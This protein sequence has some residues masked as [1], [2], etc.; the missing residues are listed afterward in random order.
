MAPVLAPRSEHGLE[1]DA[2]WHTE[3]EI[4]QQLRTS[5][6]KRM[7]DLSIMT[8]IYKEARSERLWCSL[9][10]LQG[11]EHDLTFHGGVDK[12][13]HQYCPQHYSL[14]VAEYPDEADAFVPGAFGENVVSE[15]MYEGNVC[16]GDVVRIGGVLL[17]VSLP[18]Q[19]CFKLNHR[20]GIKGFAS[21]TWRKS[22]TGWYY[23][24]LVEGWMGVGDGITLV[25]RKWPAWTIERV[26]E[27]LHRDTKNLEK[28]EELSQIDA[29]G[30]EC[31][32][33]FKRMIAVLKA[34]EA[35]KSKPKEVFEKYKLVEKTVQTP[36]ITSFTFAKPGEGKAIDPGSF[37]RLQL[38]NGLLRSY[39]IVSGNTHRFQVGIALDDQS[40][41]GS[42][43][44]HQDLHLGDALLAG[45]I[46]P[47][48]PKTGDASNH[49][50][51]VGGI[52]ITAFLALI[53]RFQAI[54][55][56]YTLHYAVRS[57]E[58]IPYRKAVAG[59]GKNCVVYAKDEGRRMDIE[60]I[61]RKRAWNSMVYICGPT[62]MIAAVEEAATAL[63]IE[64][65]E[66]H[67]EAFQE[68]YTGDP[69]EI[70]VV[71][72]AASSGKKETR[73]VV[74]DV[75]GDKTLLSVLREAGL[76]IDSSCEVGNCGA[77]TVMVKKGAVEHRGRALSAE[78][79]AE[80]AMLACVSRGVGRLRLEW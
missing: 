59:M 8:G 51:L 10:G 1:P 14:W 15:R 43:F 18:R 70:E 53:E 12:A 57:R 7:R 47:S 72:G 22:R 66:V 77:C 11:D 35:E 71:G 38:P 44:L 17:Q 55:Y 67:Y 68:N 49:I 50:F 63:G 80:G 60:R 78:E 4:V 21:E 40:R 75:P 58:E 41:G 13:V 16:I 34:T 45:H 64:D 52:G 65:G 61:L 33:A 46:T 54:N 3:T 48:V 19:L 79:K 9:L 30:A 29:F 23:R 6:M 42:K 76:E 20:F 31:K 26:Q 69:F 74:L 39:S 56:N 62:R 32:K 24:V 27:Y 73:A 5:K 2:S 36:R 28:L 37:V 25:E